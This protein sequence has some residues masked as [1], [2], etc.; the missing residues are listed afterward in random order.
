M[1]SGNVIAVDQT[2]GNQP[3]SYGAG[4]V[5][6][7][8]IAETDCIYTVVFPEIEGI[9]PLFLE[10]GSESLR[11]FHIGKGAHLNCIAEAPDSG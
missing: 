4:L 8:K 6:R 11:V 7:G 5:F 3:A 9:K 10:C 1:W 2:V